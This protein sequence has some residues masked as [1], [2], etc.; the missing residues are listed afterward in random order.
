MKQAWFSVLKR[1]LQLALRRKTDVA[2]ILM[3]F[4]IVCSLFPLGTNPSPALLQQAAPSVLWVA[5]LLASLLSLPRLFA[6]DYADGS[7]EQL[8]L[9]GQPLS[10][11]VTAKVMAHW[12][13]S[14]LPIIII[15]P[16]IG[17]LYGLP[18]NALFMIMLALLLGTPCLSLVGAIGAALTLGVRG[19]GLLIAL[20]VLPLYIPILIFGSG[21]V[22]ANQQAMHTNAYLLLLAAA[23]LTAIALAPWAISAA[24]KISVE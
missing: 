8:M 2:T 9:S 16:L 22:V 6:T 15:A 12:L 21:A 3:F 19:S 11:L 17:V 5:T 20:L 13:V 4:I 7:L 10:L 14:C 23:S 18:N 24:L 1:D